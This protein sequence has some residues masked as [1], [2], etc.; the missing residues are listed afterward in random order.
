MG[1]TYGFVGWFHAD[2]F[3]SVVE[4]LAKFENVGEAGKTYSRMTKSETIIMGVSYPDEEYDCFSR[5]HYIEIE[6]GSPAYDTITFRIG[7]TAMSSSVIQTSLSILKILE[8]VALAIKPMIV[9]SYAHG[10]SEE[11]LN[12]PTF[13]SIVENS[14]GICYISDDLI[15]QFLR[16]ENENLYR[17]RGCE[18]GYIFAS[19][20][21][22]GNERI[23]RMSDSHGSQYDDEELFELLRE[24]LKKH[25]TA[26]KSLVQSLNL[27]F[28]RG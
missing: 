28:P 7:M 6:K 24:P 26:I 8:A 3:S 25:V 21:G 16:E 22:A 27:P 15:P 23:Y 10:L 12:N 5:S 9:V 18:Y 11:L 14:D 4:Q 13:D 19:P 20:I 1:L 17:V 2:R